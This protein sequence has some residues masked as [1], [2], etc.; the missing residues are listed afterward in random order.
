MTTQ[1]GLS[2]VVPVIDP[3]TF[4][5][6]SIEADGATSVGVTFRTPYLRVGTLLVDGA[7][8]CLDL[9]TDQARVSVSTTG[10]VM[11]TAD[12]LAL[13]RRLH[14]ATARYLADCERLH[15]HNQHARNGRG[16]A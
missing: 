16:A 13:A 2:D 12:D 11:V 1:I 5:T 10:G 8:P 7:R 4:L 3:Y 6:I 14:A 9:A 15:R